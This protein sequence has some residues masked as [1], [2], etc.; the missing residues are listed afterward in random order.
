M[1]ASVQIRL[2]EK[3]TAPI[4]NI[5]HTV[6]NMIDTLETAETA[7]NNAFDG[8]AINGMRHQVEAVQAEME[9][10]VN[11]TA[12][13]GREL[14]NN[15]KK[16]VELN[17]ETMKMPGII[18]GILASA[19]TVGTVKKVAEISD[20]ITQTRARLD[21]MN[22]G[23][24][25]TD[26][27][28]RMVQRSAQRARGDYMSMAS[29]V[30]RFG[31]NAGDA[32]ADTAEIVRFSELV[33]KQ[34]TIAGASTAEAGNAMLQLS[35]ALGSGVLRGDELNSI[36][37]Q[38]P[39]LIRT[40]ADYLHVPIG[41]IRSMAAEG[42]LTADIVKKAILSSADEINA[43]FDKMPI[44]WGQ[45][46]Q[47]F[48]NEALVAFE[49][50]LTK[51]NEIANSE[52]FE[53]FFSSATSLLYIFADVAVYALNLLGAAASFV[54]DKWNVLGP[55]IMGV[56][57]ALAAAKIALAAVTI[58]QTVLNAAVWA[59]PLTWVIVAIA[60]IIA[61]IY[62]T[63]NAINAVT[64]K[65]YSGTGTV[66][67]ILNTASAVVNN[68]LLGMFEFASAGVEKTT[69]EF[70]AFANFLGN[71]FN[72]PIGSIIHLFG[73]LHDAVFGVLENIAKAMDHLFGTNFAGVMSSYRAKLNSYTNSLAEKLGNGKYETKVNK[74]EFDDILKSFGFGTERMS[75]KTAWNDGY[76][77]GE[78]LDTYGMSL[79][80]PK[81]DAASAINDILSAQ[82][83]DLT[84]IAGAANA[85]AND[86]SNISDRLNASDEDL[87]MLRDMAEREA[88][89]RFTTAEVKVE[90]GG[91]TN[92]LNSDT[93]I[94]GFINVLTE[95]VEEA[96]QTTAEGVHIA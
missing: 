64:N 27:L 67:G 51:I 43:Q 89:N 9:E 50:V 44:T 87:R 14:Q 48:K 46:V 29:V 40:I 74:V 83:P 10:L 24:Q 57:T 23:L 18:K 61:A 95:R 42:E 82:I 59:C 38:A 4:N 75:Y 73:D 8:D 86:T 36:F 19:A 13:V 72:D 20:E 37:E 28:T 15:T 22:D 79:F 3:M 31:N 7:Q 69:N 53:E 12:K 71:V 49:P 21:M 1:A 81:S 65:T 94:D 33:Q 78:G 92:N 17:G 35:Q 2:V 96:M 58:A 62:A 26:E 56:V 41:Q 25:T 93:D 91:I 32:F 6:E 39:N 85:I 90:F 55:V 63:V 68:L 5:I 70:V 66:L 30:A 47:A 34:M 16:Q 76:A 45:R 80:T 88:V 11:D 77:A 60:L 54:Y 52:K 84:G